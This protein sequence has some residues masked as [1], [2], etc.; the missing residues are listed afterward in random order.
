M[1]TSFP[2]NI[3]TLPYTISILQINLCLTNKKPVHSFLI[4]NLFFQKIT[5]L[6]IKNVILTGNVYL[7]TVPMYILFLCNLINKD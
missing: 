2:I 7:I 5:P 1:S 6:K 4:V 3:K